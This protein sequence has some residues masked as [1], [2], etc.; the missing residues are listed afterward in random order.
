M[1]QRTDPIWSVVGPECPR[2]ISWLAKQTGFGYQHIWNVRTGR[3]KASARFRAA[4]ALA[5]NLPEKELFL[6]EQLVA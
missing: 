2:S 1:Q 6:D 5:L 3:G 4:C